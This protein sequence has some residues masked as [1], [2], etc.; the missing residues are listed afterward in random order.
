M[1]SLLRATAVAAAMIALGLIAAAC[2]QTVGR[3]LD[4]DGTLGNE[5]NQVDETTGTRSTDMVNKIAFIGSNGDLFI[6]NPDG[7][8]L[9]NLTGGSRVS[10]GSQGGVLAHSEGPI[11]NY[12]W[13]TWSPDGTTIAASRVS[14]TEGRPEVSVEVF[15]AAGGGGRT[16]YVNPVASMIAQGAPHYLYW[17][18]DSRNLALLVSAPQAFALLALDTR[19]PDAGPENI[20]DVVETGAPLYFHWNQVGDAILIHSR[21]E[22][23]LVRRPFG[24]ASSG[25]MNVGYGFRAPAFSPDGR[26]MAYTLEN[27]DT[28][29]AA[30]FVEEVG[31]PGSATAILDV[32]S[33]TAFAWSPDGAELA[34]VDQEGSG[35]PMFQRLMLVPA[36]GGAARTLAQ[37]P[38]SAFFWAPTGDKIAWVSVDSQDRLLA[39]KVSPVDAPAGQELLR[40]HPSLDTMTMLNFFDQYAY[41]H[42]P[43]SPDGNWLVVAGTREER[44]THRN[45]GPPKGERIFILDATGAADPREL[46]EGSLGFWS[47]N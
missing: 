2:N 5:A 4:S 6:V 44:Y 39:L 46:A 34:V 23:N 16:V 41:S 15:D 47:W 3:S 28:A 29:G 11:D 38:I 25:A 1:R 33:L 8:E 32:K 26:R 14:A 22:L 35:S 12:F 9:F 24:G 27:P 43:W 19:D 31:N 37:E 7:A 36:G 17:S 42:S 20:P 45:G 13:P 10:M 40:F 21:D 30:L 18:P